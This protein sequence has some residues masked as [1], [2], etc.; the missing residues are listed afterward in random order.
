VAVTGSS[1]FSSPDEVAPNENPIDDA[2][3]VVD[4]EDEGAPAPKLNP[5]TG[6]RIGASSSDASTRERLGLAGVVAVEVA[7]AAPKE[8]PPLLMAPPPLEGSVAPPNEK[9]L[10]PM[11]ALLS[12]TAAA[13]SM[14]PSVF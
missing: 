11:L 10:A 14:P 2:A 8:N 4:V 3:L 9:P 5:T 6:A 7:V 1:F 12:F 13:P